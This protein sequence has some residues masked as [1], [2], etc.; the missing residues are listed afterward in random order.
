MH[1]T[2]RFIRSQG[3]LDGACFLYALLNARQTLTG[4]RA[5]ANSW[6]AAV[7]ILTT[8]ECFIDNTRGS[9]GTDGDHEKERDLAERFIN[10][11]APAAPLRVQT[12]KGLKSGI[13]GAARPTESSVIVCSNNQHWFSILDADEDRVYVACSWVWQRDPQKYT[14]RVSPG[15]ER[16]YNDI[17]TIG[18]LEFYKSR[19]LIVSTSEA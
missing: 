10:H 4:K 3:D 7:R 16:V 6:S 1:P 13:L 8:P 9:E 11:L 5:T 14:E 12:A 15:F 2:F 18:D 17:V 19:A